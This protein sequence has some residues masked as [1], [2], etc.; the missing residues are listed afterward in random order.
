MG[1]IF[2]SH[3][4]TSTYSYLQ[5]TPTFISYISDCVLTI[6]INFQLQK[7]YYTPLCYIKI[8]IE[9]IILII[10]IIDDDDFST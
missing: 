10:I 9:W 4:D 2:K 7:F 8:N 3:V 6:L 1:T 5:E